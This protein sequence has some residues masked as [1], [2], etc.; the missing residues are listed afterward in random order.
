MISIDELK[1]DEKGLIPAVVQDFETGRVLWR[2][3]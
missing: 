1:Y 2:S 3:A